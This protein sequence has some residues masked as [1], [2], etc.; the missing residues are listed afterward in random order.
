MAA[1]QCDAVVRGGRVGGSAALAGMNCPNSDGNSV[2][3]MGTIGNAAN[4]FSG[5]EDKALEARG[6]V[7]LVFEV[8]E[9]ELTMVFTME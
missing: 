2:L 4:F 7:L 8:E 6:W 3:G 1:W 5:V 9:E